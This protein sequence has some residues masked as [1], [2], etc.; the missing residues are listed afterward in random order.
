MSRNIQEIFSKIDELA[1]QGC[2][3]LT[4][5]EKEKVFEEQRIK[6]YYIKGKR[7]G[8]ERDIYE[9]D[10]KCFNLLWK[11]IYPYVFKSALKSVHYDRYIVDDAVSEIKVLVFKYLRS[12]GPQAFSKYVPLLVNNVLT[13]FSNQHARLPLTVPLTQEFVEE[14]GEETLNVKVVATLT[15]ESVEYQQGLDFYCDIPDFLKKVVMRLITG[16]TIS[17]VAKEFNIPYLK[18]DLQKQFAVLK[19]M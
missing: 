10:G 7:K 2:R 14:T 19:K 4:S 1:E 12:F 16:D 15:Q 5:Q 13:N 18:R 8:E 9:V 6:R 11:E 17:S 3:L